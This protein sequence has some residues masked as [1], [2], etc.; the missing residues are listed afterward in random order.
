MQY[1]LLPTYFDFT[2]VHVI[3]Y[4]IQPGKEHISCLMLIL[5]FGVARKTEVKVGN[6]CMPWIPSIRWWVEK[7]VRFYK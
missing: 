1:V 6:S 2:F 7:G 5:T 3:S 4:I